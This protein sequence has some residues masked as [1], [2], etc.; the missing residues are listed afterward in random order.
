MQTV[1]EIV[2]K[3]ADEDPVIVLEDPM[4]RDE[5]RRDFRLSPGERLLEMQRRL[6]RERFVVGNRLH[7]ITAYLGQVGQLPAH[8]LSAATWARNC[9]RESAMPGFAS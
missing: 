2:R 4:V 5:S 7:E 8:F 3:T 1:I 9:S 6:R